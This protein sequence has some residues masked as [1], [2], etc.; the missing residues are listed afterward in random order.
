MK[1]YRKVITFTKGSAVS[2]RHCATRG[3]ASHHQAAQQNDN[4]HNN[5]TTV[6]YEVTSSSSTRQMAERLNEKGSS[7]TPEVVQ[8]RRHCAK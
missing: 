2:A 4:N 6:T 1:K 5:I 3:R 7:R 8:Y